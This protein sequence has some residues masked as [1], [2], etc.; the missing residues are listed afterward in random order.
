MFIVDA[1]V[2]TIYAGWVKPSGWGF[3]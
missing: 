3:D 2:A 1:A